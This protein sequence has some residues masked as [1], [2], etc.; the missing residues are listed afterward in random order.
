VTRDVVLDAGALIA[1]ERGERA[2]RAYVF[3]ADRGDVALLTS[4]A[5][6]AQV[7]RGGARQAR[8]AR[9]LASELV[10][11]V[12]LDADASRRVG[13]LAA[14]VGASDV[15][16]GHVATIAMERDAVVVTSDADDIV[17]WGVDR[18]RIVRC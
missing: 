12:A 15:V 11:E 14:A 16:D 3:L 1:L 13:M 9:L 2:L 5:V 17:R 8:L 18:A 6:V 4:S 7:W 10:E